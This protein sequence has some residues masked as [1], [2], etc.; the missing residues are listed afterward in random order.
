MSDYNAQNNRVENGA[1]FPIS[2]G[3]N[4]LGSEQKLQAV[5]HANAV[6]EQRATPGNGSQPD[7]NL[8]THQTAILAGTKTR[9]D[10]VESGDPRQFRAVDPGGTSKIDNGDLPATRTDGNRTFRD[11]R[12]ESVV[13]AP[14]LTT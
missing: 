5:N 7:P 2:D 11:R 6:F 13:K 1:A 14:Y 8:R 12:D 3:G 4:Q 9:V 10:R